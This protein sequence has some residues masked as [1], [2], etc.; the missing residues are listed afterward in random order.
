MNIE[1]TKSAKKRERQNWVVQNATRKE[2]KTKQIPQKN[3]SSC[4]IAM[5]NVFAM[6]VVHASRNTFENIDHHWPIELAI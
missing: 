1:H 5:Q 2:A 6:N 4:E 3:V